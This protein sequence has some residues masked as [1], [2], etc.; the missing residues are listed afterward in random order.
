MASYAYHDLISASQEAG[1][2]VC[3]LVLQSVD[4]YFDNLFYE[5]VNDWGIR[6]QL[7]RSLGFCNVHAW[8]AIE[9]GHGDPLGVSIIYHDILSTLLKRLPQA[10][11]RASPTKRILARLGRLPRQLAD[12]IKITVQALTPQA[13]CPACEQRD[14]MT[15]LYLATL[16]TNL[17]DGQ[18]AEAFLQ[19]DG[20]CLPHL[21]Q[22]FSMARDEQAYRILLDASREKLSTLDE[23]LS[24]IIRKS[25]YR[26]HGEGFGSERDA[27]RR[28]IGAASGGKD[29]Y[30]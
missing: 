20:L 1:C 11:D 9:R 24:E 28:V 16:V 17:D 21:R 25:D 19:S 2:P 12:Q 29:A 30:P 10:T 3:R 6:D 7:R 22:A 26:F 13:A 27:W 18:L 8:L 5:N 15:R 23:Q 4:R 14:K